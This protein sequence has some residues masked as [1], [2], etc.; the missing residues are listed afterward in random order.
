MNRNLPLKFDDQ[1]YT[2]EINEPS[3]CPICK[4]AISPVTVSVYPYKSESSE[5]F[6]SIT[7]LCKN[8]YNTFLTRDSCTLFNRPQGYSTRHEYTA[9]RLYFGPNKFVEEPFE[10]SI[11]KLSPKFVKIYNQALA[12]EC[13]NLDE[14]AGIGYRKSVEFLV[15]D[16][17]IHAAPDDADSIKAMPLAKCIQKYITIPN[18][19]TLLSRATWIGNDETHYERKHEDLNLDNMKD[20]IKAAVYF[21]SMSLLVEKAGA[22]APG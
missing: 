10:P 13:Y 6:V 18:I 21:I 16:Y 4:H 19:E 12:A 1:Q 7:Y 8:C 11:V 20:F 15:K 5:A 14:I 22:I 9:K 2:G 3:V 17:A